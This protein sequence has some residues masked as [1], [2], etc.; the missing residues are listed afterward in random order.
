MILIEH[1]LSVI[2]LALLGVLGAGHLKNVYVH[3]A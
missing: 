1:D 3:A 2:Y